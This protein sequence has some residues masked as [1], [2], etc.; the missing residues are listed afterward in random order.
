MMANFIGDIAMTG[1][2]SLRA[3]NGVAEYHNGGNVWFVDKFVQS[4]DEVIL[5][6]LP[7]DEVRDFFSRYLIT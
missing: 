5:V 4:F 6:E 3:F 1:K 2:A 7:I